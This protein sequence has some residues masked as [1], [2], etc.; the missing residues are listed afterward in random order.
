MSTDVKAS[1]AAELANTPPWNAAH[2][3]GERKCNDRFTSVLVVTT[4]QDIAIDETF[5]CFQVVSGN[6]LERG[7]HLDVGAEIL[8]VPRL[9]RNPPAATEPGSLS[10]GVTAPSRR[11]ISCLRARAARPRELPGA[12]HTERSARKL[13]RFPP[14]PHWL[15]PRPMS[16]QPGLRFRLQL[17]LHALNRASRS[18]PG[19]RR[20]PSVAPALSPRGRCPRECR[21]SV[22][23]DFPLYRLPAASLS[24]R[25]RLWIVRPSLR[26]QEA[27]ASD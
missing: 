26:H 13:L 23:C 19:S 5:H 22:S 10:A 27:R 1:A 7:N 17:R 16:R 15:R 3:R 2:P 14:R 4:H 6:V 8:F 12:P 21:S 20:E 11:P 9:R 25:E 24:L 18:R